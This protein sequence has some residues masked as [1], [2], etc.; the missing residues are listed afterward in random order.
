MQ[1][2]KE[3]TEEIKAELK[4]YITDRG[5][6]PC[7]VVIQVGDRPESNSYVRG[8]IARLKE[9][10]ER[11]KMVERAKR[12]MTFDEE[13]KILKQEFNEII[14]GEDKQSEP[15]FK[16]CV[17]RRAMRCI[18]KQYEELLA[19]KDLEEQGLL[20]KLPCKVGDMVYVLEPC[21]CYNNYKENQ[22]CHRAKTKAT[23]YIEVV[24]VSKKYNSRSNTNCVKLYE[25]P[26]KMDYLTKIGK[27]V[28]LT[29]EEAE[30][31]LEMEK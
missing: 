25:R 8:K 7:L 5:L 23:K 6:K 13:Y 16:N 1:S 19:Y 10:L 17:L 24:R 27:T 22:N 4:Q 9:E 29:K 2:V 18:R 31:A 26:F 28:F 14:E 15:P 21:H 3:Y 11:V 30:K 12:E 20:L